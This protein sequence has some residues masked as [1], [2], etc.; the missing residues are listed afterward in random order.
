MKRSDFFIRLTTGVL[1]LAVA[2]YIGVYLYNALIT[3]Y[4]TTAAI[5]YAIEETLS[6]QGY[7][8]RTET[9]LADDGIAVLPIANEG[10]KIAAGQVIAIEYM[11]L[12]ALET[13]SEIRSLRLMIAQ[14]EFAR[15]LNDATAFDAIVE[16]SAAVNNN[17][18]KRLDEIS[19]IIDTSI[20]AVEPDIST[21]QQRLNELEGRGAGARSVI[22]QIS[23]TFSHVIDGFEHIDPNMLSGISPTDLSAL[24]AVSSRN[25]RGT[26]K[27][28]TEFKWYY[29]AIMDFDEASQLSVGQTKAVQ[30]FGSFNAEIDM[31]IENISRR[32]DDLCV[33][34]FSSDRGIHDVAPLRELRA[35]IVFNVV[36]GIR[37]PKDAIHLDDELN[38]FVYLQTSGF[39]ERVDVEILMETGD[40]YLVR[41]GA[42][43][44]S[45]L[46]VDSIII[47][48]A[49][50][51]Y[52]GKVV[53]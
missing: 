13:A 21:L 53:T 49:N 11:S 52:H 12:D 10:E 3:T 50:N 6:A 15:S 8:V 22:A 20:F 43:T 47:V 4:S 26:G 33:V 36:T 45:P 48:R 9:V 7:I 29:A 2:F 16:L 51:L 19:L 31:L 35:D 38:T 42:E 30:F 44:G 41:D 1:F 39:A 23:G 17:D 28:I 40:S 18:L 5:S 32:E 37:V 25:S 14:L 46:R 27:L 24:F 34:L